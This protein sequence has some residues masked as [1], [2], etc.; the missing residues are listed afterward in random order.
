MTGRDEADTKSV[1]T[2]QDFYELVTKPNSLEGKRF[3][4]MKNLL[5]D[6]AIYKRTIEKLRALGAT[7]VELSP[8][9]I[10][11]NHFLSILNI[12][13][14]NDLPRY[15]TLHTYKEQVPVRSITD[16]VAFN[17]ADSITRIPYGQALFRYIVG[18]RT[19]KEELQNI[20]SDLERQGRSFFDSGLDTH[21]LDAILSINN[22][23][24]GYA[25]VAKYPALCIPMG[26]KTN[27]EP[28]NLT[29][30]GKPFQEDKL[31]GLGL[32]F[33]QATE[34]RE[35]PAEMAN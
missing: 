20:K 1:A 6:D 4:A 13:M 21:S 34:V 27:G 18:D 26:Y 2:G 33:E 30:I 28:V 29:F 24:S 19:T 8:T 31:L 7:V 15:L 32:A 12:D 10:K 23:H 17:A 11:M 5:E 9:K 25:A 3:G 22:Y 16:V 35:I 14:R